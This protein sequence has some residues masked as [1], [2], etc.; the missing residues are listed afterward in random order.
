MNWQNHQKATYRLCRFT[1]L[2]HDSKQ[3]VV[4]IIGIIITCEQHCTA[5]TCTDNDLSI[6]RNTER[7]NTVIKHCADWQI[8]YHHHHRFTALFLGPPG[9]AGARRELLDFMVQG[10]INRGRHTVH[11]AGRYSNRTNQC[12]PPPCPQ[13]HWHWHV[14]QSNTRLTVKC[15]DI[16]ICRTLCSLSHVLTSFN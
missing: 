14:L 13:M 11:P 7:C 1:R 8:H 2:W 4:I 3:V 6:T 9:W 10:K 5:L 15:C 16:W 12:P